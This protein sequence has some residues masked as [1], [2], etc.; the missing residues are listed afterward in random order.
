MDIKVNYPS[1]GTNPLEITKYQFTKLKD[2]D[3]VKST[4]IRTVNNEPF[5]PTHFV[6]ITYTNGFAFTYEW[7]PGREV[8]SLV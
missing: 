2:S 8:W 4:K 5:P 1:E 6:D 7:N 3:K